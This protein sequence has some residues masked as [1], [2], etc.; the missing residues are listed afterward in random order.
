MKKCEKFLL[1]LG[2]A[3]S[4][5]IPDPK[6]IFNTENVGKEAEI[7]FSSEYKYIKKRPYLKAAVI[8][9]SLAAA[10]AVLV[11]SFNNYTLT[12]PINSPHIT[13]TAVSDKA[14]D[15]SDISD[16]SEPYFDEKS[17]L[18]PLNLIGCYIDD[19]REYRVDTD[20]WKKSDNFDLFRQYFFALWEN[21]E[22]AFGERL[23]V[24]VIDD[25]EKSFFAD[26]RN[27]R[28]DGFYKPSENVLAFIINDNAVKSIFWIDLNDP[29]TMYT[30]SENSGIILR[31]DYSK[32]IAP[33]ILT[34]SD[35]PINNP[36]NNY[37]S[38]FR[39]YEMSRDHKID[40]NM[41]VNIEHK[42]YF[43]QADTDIN[44]SHDDWYQFYPVYLVSESEDKIKL[45]TKVGNII[46]DD[47]EAEAE[48]AFE[49]I[50]GEWKRKVLLTF[51]NGEMTLLAESLSAALSKNDA[52][53]AMELLNYQTNENGYWAD[54]SKWTE[55]TDYDIFREYFF[56]AWEINKDLDFGGLDPLII[57][58][59]EKASVVT[60]TDEWYS[61]PFYRVN[62]H[63]LAFINGNS[64]G[65]SI[66]WLD[67]NVPDIL[68]VSLGGPWESGSKLM[69]FYNID[70]EA[71]SVLAFKKTDAEPNEPQNGFLSIYKLYELSQKHGI[72]LEMLAHIEYSE[73]IDL[74]HDVYANFYPMYLLTETETEIV[75]KTILRNH[76]YY[77]YEDK[78]NAVEA[79]NTIE[80]INGEWIKKVVLKLPNG[81]TVALS[82]GSE[83]AD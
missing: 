25:S 57:D 48:C 42:I 17:V 51:P 31:K 5:H 20:K 12:T 4:R 24:F 46:Y 29:N 11:T 22:A 32:E 81:E 49:R 54:G 59:S 79:I 41:L 7:H 65:P 69:Y 1:A 6:E 76:Y 70:N 45:K 23:S 67:A 37:L 62:D 56:G 55:L 16:R 2:K 72:S 21:G 74:T 26:N 10:A 60:T 18:S 77:Y 58:D 71:P 34:K 44:I 30:E 73:A 40:F 19:K 66:Y 53:S 47:S 15:I 39:L 80:K 27:W 43:E 36:D 61:G 63:V 50:D 38:I 68:Y 9:A 83:S 33:A 8:T 52:L 28:F 64:G 75:I 14:A 82:D 78:Y 3:D 35:A 13:E